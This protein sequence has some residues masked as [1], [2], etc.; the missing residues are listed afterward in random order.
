MHDVKTWGPYYMGGC[1]RVKALTQPD[2]P[3]HNQMDLITTKMLMFD[4]DGSYYDQKAAWEARW[5]LSQPVCTLQ[6]LLVL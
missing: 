4:Q 1:K 5:T 3:Y 2:G 6:L